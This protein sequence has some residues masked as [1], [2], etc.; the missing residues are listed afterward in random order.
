[1][2]LD[3]QVAIVTGAGR[4][5]GQQIAVRLAQEGAFVVIADMDEKG[6]EETAAMIVNNCGR[7]SKV[8]PTDIT[9]EKQVVS[10]AEGS[11]KIDNRIDILVNN[12]GIAGPI[13]NIED[14]SLEEWE[15]TSAV[16][17]RGMFLCCKYVIPIMKQ[18]KR[19]SIVNISSIA[20]KRPMPQR[21]PYA[22]TKMGVI[23]FTR[24]LA[25]EVGRWNIRV[26]T[27]C[28]GDVKSKRLDMVLG[29]MGRSSGK[30]WEQI[31]AERIEASALKCFVEP[32]DIGAVIAFLCSEDAAMIT[33]EDINVSAGVVMY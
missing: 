5:I 13:K 27:I 8:I 14:I 9:Y 18:Q 1:M 20:G 4:G 19:G 7:K 2:S 29:E 21:T 22:T 6:S 16:N 15:A 33:G 31:V 11:L 32:K 23:G 17:L 28:P 25:A 12:C 26:N 24:T 3:K 30:S 10:L